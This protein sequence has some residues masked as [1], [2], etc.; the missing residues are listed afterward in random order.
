MISHPIST[1]RLGAAFAP[2]LEGLGGNITLSAW[3]GG[4]RNARD[5]SFGIWAVASRCIAKR[6]VYIRIIRRTISVTVRFRRT[7][8]DIVKPWR[9]W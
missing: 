5:G 2:A 8:T 3:R 7:V 6:D 9:I 4:K 1:E